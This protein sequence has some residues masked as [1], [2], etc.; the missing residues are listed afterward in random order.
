MDASTGRLNAYYS[1]TSSTTITYCADMDACSNGDSAIFCLRRTYKHQ[2][3][4]VKMDP[5]SFAISMGGYQDWASQSGYGSEYNDS[6]RYNKTLDRV[7]LY[8]KNGSYAYFRLLT[9][10]SFASPT[11]SSAANEVQASSIVAY[12]DGTFSFDIDTSGR[13]VAYF[14]DG[15]NRTQVVLADVTASSISVRHVYQYSTADF[16][17]GE[18]VYDSAIDKFL[19]VFLDSTS[20][21]N[22]PYRGLTIAPPASG[23]LVS[24][25]FTALTSTNNNIEMFA[26]G[27]GVYA[28]EALGMVYLTLNGSQNNQLEHLVYR[29]AQSVTNLTA[30]NFI[31]F[32]AGSYSANATAT[33]N[34]V[35]TA[36]GSQSGLTAGKKHYVQADGALSTTAGTPS[37]YAGIATSASNI[38]VKG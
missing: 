27:H 2:T 28:P 20:T 35:G 29:S 18:I 23:N 6:I 37:V 32:A 26:Y 12:H 24:G 22:R 16:D 14:T 38:I 4:V 17:F 7:C 30:E 13:L 5:S 10:P 19:W 25:S 9:P 36:Q 15:S 3:Q 11:M 1:E 31:G 33:I 34:L 21:T 8:Y